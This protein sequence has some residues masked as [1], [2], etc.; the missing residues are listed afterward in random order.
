[1]NTFAS[2]RTI[3]FSRMDLVDKAD[4]STY[5]ASDD[6]TTVTSTT[7]TTITTTVNSCPDG[8]DGYERVGN[9]RHNNDNQLIAYLQA[10]ADRNTCAELCSSTAE[11]SYFIFKNING[12]CFHF[13]STPATSANNAFIAHTRLFNCAA[14][15]DT[16]PLCAT[17]ANT[18]DEGWTALCRPSCGVCVAATTSTVTV[19]TTTSTTT[20]LRDGRACASDDTNVRLLPHVHNRHCFPLPI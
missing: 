7:T 6:C 2:F 12:A 20:A 9:R 18:C 14:C 13:S 5:I 16:H 1:M 11:C 10:I 17:E 8:L 4:F 19:G 3:Q 15:V